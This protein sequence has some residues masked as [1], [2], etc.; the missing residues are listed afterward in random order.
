MVESWNVG[1]NKE[2]IHTL[3]LL[4]SLPRGILPTTHFSIFPEPII[5]LFHHS[6]I[7]IAERSG[8]KFDIDQ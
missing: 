8:A 6:I 4:S 5:P 2:V 3:T 1:F 7:P